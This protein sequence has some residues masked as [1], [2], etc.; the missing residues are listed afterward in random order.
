MASKRITSS[1]TNC[2][3]NNKKPVKRKMFIEKK[4]D[5]TYYTNDN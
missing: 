4:R 5:V 3:N 1:T 2:S